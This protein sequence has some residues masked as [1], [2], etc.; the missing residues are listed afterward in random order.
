MTTGRTPGLRCQLAAASLAL[1]LTGVALAQPAPAASAAAAA[2]APAGLLFAVEI[3]TGPAWDTAK[4]PQDQAH[5]RE[6]S[7]HLR[8]LRD[9]GVLVMG[10]RYGDKGLVVL[11]AAS[12][13]EAQALMK[14]DP[15]IQAGVFKVE[16]HEF[17]VFYGG[18]LAP[19]ARPR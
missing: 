8:R 17:R 4:S 1:L 16:L 15:S 2:T 9:Q 13:S 18:T 10:A 6:H 12:E 5:F 7:A 14:D 3:T 19:P 11:R